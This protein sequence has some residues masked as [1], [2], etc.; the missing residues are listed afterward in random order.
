MVRTEAKEVGRK[1]HGLFGVVALIMLVSTAGTYQHSLYEHVR[2]VK[3]IRAVTSPHEVASKDRGTIRGV[4]WDSVLDKPLAGARV[5]LVPDYE[6]TRSY[7]TLSDSSGRFEYSGLPPARYWIGFTHQK[8]D[9]LRIH[10]AQSVVDLTGSLLQTVVLAVPSSAALYQVH[11]GSAPTQQQA[12][13]LGSVTGVPA[14]IAVADSLSI[15][16]VWRSVDTAGQGPGLRTTVV[17]ALMGT[18]GSFA[19]CGLPIAGG[20]TVEF[21]RRNGQRDSIAFEAHPDRLFVRQIYL[22]SRLASSASGQAACGTACVAVLRGKLIDNVGNPVAHGEVRVASAPAVG[23]SD[24]SGLFAI[25]LVPLGSTNL[26]ARSIGYLPV[27]MVVDV[28]PSDS[29]VVQ[30]R[31]GKP[32]SMLAAVRVRSSRTFAGFEQRRATTSRGVFLDES[33]IEAI[34]AFHVADLFDRL[35]GVEVD[36]TSMVRATI[37]T[38][39]G[40][41]TCEP[42]VYVDGRPLLAKTKD[43]DA[44]MD[45]RRLRGIE[46]YSFP[47]EVPSEFLGNP[48]CGAILFWMKPDS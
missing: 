7:S 24:A 2:V 3:G 32:T 26:H 48:F 22:N 18:E 12:V 17:P 47:A 43:L 9:L 44:F 15:K 41:G 6:R 33:Q 30:V 14:A 34:R 37:R 36:R 16:A 46:V 25:H 20:F 38:R 13:M 28:L 11:C 8:L 45:P 4:V 21:Q 23:R 19:L 5:V 1:E 39:F 10:A 27:S 35:P 29:M 40:R 42:S 31:M